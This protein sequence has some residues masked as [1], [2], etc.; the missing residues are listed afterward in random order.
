MGIDFI[1]MNGSNNETDDV[2]AMAQVMS[3]QQQ[4]DGDMTAVSF[5]Q[6]L[7]QLPSSGVDQLTV[8]SSSLLVE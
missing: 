2:H 7:N 3:Q 4:V 8:S 5:P 6:H 1:G